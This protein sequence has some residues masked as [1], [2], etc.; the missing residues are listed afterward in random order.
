MTELDLK[1]K[2]PNA[3]KPPYLCGIARQQSFQCHEDYR[4]NIG[5]DAARYILLPLP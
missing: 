2:A 1:T 5:A 4:S 3:A